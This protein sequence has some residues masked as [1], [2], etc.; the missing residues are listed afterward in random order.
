[1][2]QALSSKHGAL[3]PMSTQTVC[4]QCGAPI[5]I[6]SGEEC[7][8]CLMRLAIEDA[9]DREKFAQAAP[10]S[11]E[12]I[13]S[14]LED[15]SVVRLLGSGGMGAVYLA[16]QLPLN[17]LVAIKIL[18]PQRAEDPV[19]EQRFLREARA[20]AKL[21]HPHIVSLYDVGR[22]GPT[23]F[24]MMEYVEGAN[25]STDRSHQVSG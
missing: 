18:T 6:A 25:R 21:H 7:P 3:W 1:M 15:I 19:S 16:R 4:Q 12:E 24:I 2:D 17:R 11:P 13:E 10:V 20:L 22:L 5:P 14:Q 8:H 23:W 9:A